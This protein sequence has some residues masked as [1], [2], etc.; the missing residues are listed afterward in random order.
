MNR[1][2]TLLAGMAA[3]AVV[4]YA[5][6]AV[7]AW[8]RYGRKKTARLRDPLLERFFPRHEVRECHARRVSAPGS[9]T[10]AVA[11]E[12]SLHASPIVRV[13]FWLRSI[14]SL[15][16][17][18]VAPPLVE[19]R[20]IVEET[21]SIGWGMLAEVPGHE[22]V[23][24]AVTQPWKADV[25]FRAVPPARF[26]DFAEPGYVKIAWTLRAEPTGPS[27]CVFS[28]ETLAI[29]TDSES[30]RRFRRYWALLSP[31][32]RL[33]RYEMLRLVAAEAE[34]RRHVAPAMTS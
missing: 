1:A 31:G 20:G 15:L 8:C 13:I 33:I 21:L 3:V 14:P 17:G 30:R 6:H 10:L 19:G 28:T 29:A 2:I 4:G 5:V 7:T 32:I 34:R 16:R 22:I 24:G 23:M 9:L 27:A 26:A 12:A 11:K 18:T 25:V